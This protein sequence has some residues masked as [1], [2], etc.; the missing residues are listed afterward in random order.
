MLFYYYFPITP[1]VCTRNR[2][3]TYTSLYAKRFLYDYFATRLWVFHAKAIFVLSNTGHGVI[4]SYFVFVVIGP[5]VMH[6]IDFLRPTAAVYMR[7]TA[8][9]EATNFHARYAASSLHVEG[10]K[11][12]A[13]LECTYYI[14]FLGTVQIL[15]FLG[16]RQTR[17][18]DGRNRVCSMCT[19]IRIDE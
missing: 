2:P 19:Q 10:A 17:Y 3:V 18:G 1:R 12:K 13:S 16:G 7:L 6:V 11:V 15:Y 5:G 14:F 4:S 9:R 8:P